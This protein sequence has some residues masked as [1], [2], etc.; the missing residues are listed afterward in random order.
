MT[1]NKNRV[2][3]LNNENYPKKNNRFDALKSEPNK[4]NQHS[5]MNRNDKRNRNKQKDK[6]I[7]M[8][9]KKE[10]VK[11]DQNKLFSNNLEMFPELSL[12][13]NH[14]NDTKEI[15]TSYADITKPLN[16][17]KPKEEVKEG[18]VKIVR[19]NNKTEFVYK[20]TKKNIDESDLSDNADNLVDGLDSKQSQELTNLV[21][22]WEN[23]RNEQN[24]KYEEDSPFWHE[25]S[26]LDDLSDDC[27]SSESESESDESS[28]D[29]DYYDYEDDM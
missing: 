4:N 26:L 22:R 28:L 12:S 21:I 8:I 14:K 23:F 27:Y 1:N 7:N 20:D 19:K 29:D 15:E 24:E 2:N 10:N 5:K 17:E 3:S 13:K 25:K 9:I 18:W 6:Y 16:V 11:K